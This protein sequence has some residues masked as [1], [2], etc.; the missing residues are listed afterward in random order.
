[1]KWKRFHTNQRTIAATDS[2]QQSGFVWSEAGTPPAG[3]AMGIE[4]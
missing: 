1:M 2:Q 4:A 3:Y